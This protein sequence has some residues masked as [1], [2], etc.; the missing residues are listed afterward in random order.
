LKYVPEDKPKQTPPEKKDEKANWTQ[1]DYQRDVSKDY[2][3]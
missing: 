2:L 3:D 1:L